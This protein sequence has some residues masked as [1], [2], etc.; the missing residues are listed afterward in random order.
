M[1]KL[2]DI[3]NEDY[4][5]VIAS[6]VNDFKDRGLPKIKNDVPADLKYQGSAFH[7]CPLPKK[8][9]LAILEGKSVPYPPK[10]V[11][12]WAKTTKGLARIV[13]LFT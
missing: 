11:L 12:S 4:K 13:Y 2:K 1:I 7:L 10:K 9:V 8:S 6:Y 3:L 5:Q